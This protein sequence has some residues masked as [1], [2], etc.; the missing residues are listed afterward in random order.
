MYIKEIK[1]K[2]ILPCITD[3]TKIRFHAELDN[4]ISF[5]M[6]YLNRVIENAIY[7]HNANTLTIKIDAIITIYPKEIAAGQV[8]DTESVYK[9]CDWLRTKI[10]YVY[11]N[12]DKIEPLFERRRQPTALEVYKLLPQLNC[13]KCGELTCISFALK[14][15]SEEKN[16]IS[17]SEIFSNKFGEKR[18]ELFRILKDC[19]YYVPEGFV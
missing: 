7:N 10:N 6:P 8:N 2:Q 19:G 14:V 1:I 3:K 18:Q 13:K 11:D 5:L 15:L 9:I 12:K 4:D 16:I 17:C